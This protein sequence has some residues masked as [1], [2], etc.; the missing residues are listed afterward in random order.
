[1]EIVHTKLFREGYSTSRPIRILGVGNVKINCAIMGIYL[2]ATMIRQKSQSNLM[3]PRYKLVKNT[4]RL[5]NHVKQ[6]AG[7]EEARQVE[8]VLNSS[9]VNPNRIEFQWDLTFKLVIIQ[10][11]VQQCKENILDFI[12]EM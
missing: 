7:L 9:T 1:M 4:S 6:H 2:Q 12:I 11:P 3:E 5:N 10:K 8:D